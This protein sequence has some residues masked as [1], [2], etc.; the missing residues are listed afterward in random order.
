MLS[1]NRHLSKISLVCLL[2]LLFTLGALVTMN[3]TAEDANAE[4]KT[5]TTSPS[6][7]RYLDTNIGE[8][9]EAKKG[10]KVSVHYTGWLAGAGDTK[11]NQFDSSI[12]RGRPFTFSLGAG[13][14]IKGWDEGVAGMKIGGKRTLYIPSQLGYGSRGIGPIPGNADLIFDVE[15][16]G[17][18]E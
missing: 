12:S 14:V 2:G 7:L 17:V 9:A 8:G 16:L 3:S 4:A 13:Q 1:S 5:I 18:S 6:G 10:N 11:G 15:L